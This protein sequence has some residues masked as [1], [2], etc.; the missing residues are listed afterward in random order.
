MC[1]HRM[2]TEFQNREVTTAYCFYHN[3]QFHVLGE[4]TACF[5][6]FRFLWIVV[7]VIGAVSIISILNW[8][9]EHHMTNPFVTT[10]F[11]T[12]YPISQIGFPGKFILWTQNK[13]NSVN[14]WK[15]K[16]KEEKNTLER[17]SFSFPRTCIHIQTHILP[18]VHV[19][20]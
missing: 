2:Q 11:D 13:H 5:E 7:H 18:S 4:K 8:T 10:L 17:E 16:K 20:C 15:Q 1:G 14:E 19:S 3:I 12:S 6:Y 9:L